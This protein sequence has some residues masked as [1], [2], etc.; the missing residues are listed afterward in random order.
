MARPQDGN[1]ILG[2]SAFRDLFFLP[3]D[4]FTG[5]E[6]LSAREARLGA[7]SNF[8][9]LIGRIL[10]SV[11][12]IYDTLV[13]LQSPGHGADWVTRIGLPA[14]TWMLVALCQVIGGLMIIFGFWTR[15]ASLCF[16]AFCIA[17][18]VLF[19]ARPGDVGELIMGAKDLGLAGGFLFLAAGGPGRWALDR[20]RVRED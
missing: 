12:F 17:T 11:V 2:N 6:I 18:A 9:Y 16:A 5:E 7:L 19:H 15:F 13:L 3:A 4:V 8:G 14:D 10:I 20:P 1:E